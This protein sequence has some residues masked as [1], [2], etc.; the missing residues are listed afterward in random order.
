MVTHCFKKTRRST[1]GFTL[2]EL[3]VVI[4]IIGVLAALLLPALGRAKSKG[5]AISC[6]NNIRQ[7]SIAWFLYAGDHDGNLVPNITDSK[8]SS[9]KW[10]NLPGSWVVGN[11]QHDTE[12]D[13]ITDGILFPY[14]GNSGV[15]RCPSEKAPMV[16]SVGP[17][18]RAR[19]YSINAL[20]NSRGPSFIPDK[21]WGFKFARNYSQLIKPSP[22]GVFTFIDMNEQSIDDGTFSWMHYGE[23]SVVWGHQPTDRHARGANVGFADGRAETKKW[24]HP[25]VY[26]KFA[27][28]PVNAE[29]QTD[30]DWLLDRAPRW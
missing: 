16:G 21:I 14:V 4:A 20:L 26:T 6:L 3:L 1:W 28:L 7:L 23:H 11:A 9:K 17:A 2:I 22:A 5:Q 10:S 13:T 30:L 8:T 29:D 25:K 19:S 15:Y 27:Q 12:P 18:L 24:L